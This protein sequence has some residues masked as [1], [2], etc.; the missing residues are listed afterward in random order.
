MSDERSQGG[1]PAL[2]LGDVGERRAGEFLGQH[3]GRAGNGRDRDRNAA[4]QRRRMEPEDAFGMNLARGG[5][6]SVFGYLRL[7]AHERK[8]AGRQAAVAGAD[9]REDVKL[10]NRV[11]QGDPGVEIAAVGI[12]PED[13]IAVGIGLARGGAQAV[14]VALFDRSFHAQD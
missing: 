7:P 6:G 9:D 11:A 13:R 10:G 3:I 5:G 14:V 4:R 8:G 12:H 2:Q 1:S